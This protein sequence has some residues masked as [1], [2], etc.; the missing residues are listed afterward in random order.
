MGE[1]VDFHTGEGIKIKK[2]RRA[3]EAEIVLESAY[4]R[5]FQFASVIL[6]TQDKG[7]DVINVWTAA[8]DDLSRRLMAS[9]FD[10]VMRFYSDLTPGDDD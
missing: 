7:T 8:K 6:I 3:K 5:R 1:I 4:Q 2:P 9:H 10:D